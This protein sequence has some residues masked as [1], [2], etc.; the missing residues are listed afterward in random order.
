MTPSPSVSTG[1]VGQQRHGCVA[2]R[3]L[4]LSFN[5]FR[6]SLDAREP[7]QRNP[8]GRALLGLV[9]LDALFL[10]G[11]SIQTIRWPSSFL[12]AFLRESGSFDHCLEMD[13]RVLISRVL[14]WSCDCDGL[15]SLCPSVCVLYVCVFFSETNPHDRT[16]LIF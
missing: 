8:I 3:Q 13:G 9:A 6:D 14:W 11:N 10:D 5:R 12:L 15:H 16:R 2:L 7:P 1:G 4:D